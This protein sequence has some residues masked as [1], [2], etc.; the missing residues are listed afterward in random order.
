MNLD[1]FFVFC[2][3]FVFCFSFFRLS[4]PVGAWWILHQGFDLR[5]RFK[6]RERLVIVIPGQPHRVLWWVEGSKSLPQ[7]MAGIPP[8]KHK[9]LSHQAG[10]YPPDHLLCTKGHLLN[11]SHI[12]HW[13]VPEEKKKHGFYIKIWKPWHYK[14]KDVCHR[15]YQKQNKF[16]RSRGWNN[17][18]EYCQGMSKLNSEI[19]ILRMLGCTT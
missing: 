15:T 8:H 4:L 6:Q 14:F 5:L 1:L 17:I 16:W 12:H 13:T 10:A 19:L 7:M 11:P 18:T 9:Q 2:F 3:V